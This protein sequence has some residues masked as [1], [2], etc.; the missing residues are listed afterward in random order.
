MAD[1]KALARLAGPDLMHTDNYLTTPLVSSIQLL[2]I[3]HANNLP[4]NSHCI[5]PIIDLRRLSTPLT[6]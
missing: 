6:G 4:F 3:V 1:G 5:S 2:Q